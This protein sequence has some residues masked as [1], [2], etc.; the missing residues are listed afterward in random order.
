MKCPKCKEEINYLDFCGDAYYGS[1]DFGRE[2]T[3]NFLCPK[4]GVAIVQ[5]KFRIEEKDLTPELEDRL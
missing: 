2:Y 3:F 5:K 1:F 4:C